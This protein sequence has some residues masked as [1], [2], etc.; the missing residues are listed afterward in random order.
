MILFSTLTK[1]SNHSPNLINHLAASI[2]KQLSNQ[3]SDEK[4]FTESAICYENTLNNAGYTNKL[5]YDAQAQVNRKTKTN[6][7]N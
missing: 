2:E 1:K 5:V 6:I 7:A 4:I 3:F